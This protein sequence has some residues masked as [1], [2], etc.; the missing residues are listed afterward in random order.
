MKLKILKYKKMSK[1]NFYILNN[2]ILNKSCKNKKYKK[3]IKFIL[4]F[5]FNKKIFWVRNKFNKKIK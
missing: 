1:I 2:K 4:Y 5:L 3:S